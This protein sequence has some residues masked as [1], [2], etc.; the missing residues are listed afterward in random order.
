MSLIPGLRRCQSLSMMLFGLRVCVCVSLHDE[1]SHFSL[2][3]NK[4]Q[5][6]IN[7]RIF[8]PYELVSVRDKCSIFIY[9]QFIYFML[10]WT[11][12]DSTQ[13]VF[14]S[15]LKATTTEPFLILGTYN[16][17]LEG[18]GILILRVSLSAWPCV[19]SHAVA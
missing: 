8:F 7:D 1:G 13:P 15:F 10:V 11:M 6:I 5:I 9:F 4:S 14:L 18:D 17:F 16:P 3:T 12:H 19:V 2:Q